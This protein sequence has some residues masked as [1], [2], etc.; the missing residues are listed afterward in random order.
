[1]GVQVK[2]TP[3]LDG[4]VKQLEITE[5]MTENPAVGYNPSITPGALKAGTQGA[6][7]ADKAVIT[8]DPSQLVKEVTP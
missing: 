1:M 7:A 6:S 4:I 3:K 8:T 2:D 5:K